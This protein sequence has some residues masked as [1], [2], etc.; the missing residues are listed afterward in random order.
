MALSLVRSTDKGETWTH[1]Q[2]IRAAQILTKAAFDSQQIGIRDPDTGAAVR[3]GDI[4]PE[5]AVDRNPTSAGYGNLYAVWQDSR[6]SNGG[7][8]SSFSLLIDEVAFSRS[9]DGGFTWSTPIKINKTPIGI[10]LGNRQAF[11][12]AIRVAADG[13]IGVTYYDFRHNTPDP[14]TLPTDYFIVHC[15]PASVSCP[16]PTHWTETQLTAASFDMARRL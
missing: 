12:P 16:D 13:T 11:T 2:A 8:F 14:T 6:F 10:P 3:T 9:T 5:V 7:D 1:G 4:I 15:H